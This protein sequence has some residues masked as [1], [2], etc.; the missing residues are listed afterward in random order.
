MTRLFM[1]TRISKV[2][3]ALIVLELLA[4]GVCVMIVVLVVM[5]K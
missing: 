4:L 1:K 5:G 3:V 2:H